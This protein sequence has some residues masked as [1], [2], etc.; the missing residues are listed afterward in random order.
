MMNRDHIYPQSKGGCNC[1]FN[2]QTMCERCNRAKKDDLPE[3]D[4][5][6]GTPHPGVIHFFATGSHKERESDKRGHV[7]WDLGGRGPI[8][9]STFPDQGQ[10]QDK[11]RVSCPICRFWVTDDDNGARQDPTAEIC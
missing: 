2:S 4:P 10:T 8:C 1:L 11:T 6:L 7:H 3:V 5:R 9:G